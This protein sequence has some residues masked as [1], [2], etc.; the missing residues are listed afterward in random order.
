MFLRFQLMVRNLRQRCQAECRAVRFEFEEAACALTK[1]IRRLN[2][3]KINNMHNASDV[4]VSKNSPR[5]TYIRL[6]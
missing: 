6:E 3:N 5:T 4:S 1:G 2:E